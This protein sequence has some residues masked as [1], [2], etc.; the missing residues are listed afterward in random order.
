MRR[1]GLGLLIGGVLLN[2]G[3]A[4]QPSATGYV[5]CESHQLLWTIGPRAEE[6]F[7]DICNANLLTT[8]LDENYIFLP[9]DGVNPDTKQAVDSNRDGISDPGRRF[10]D[11]KD[12]PWI[13]WG[14]DNCKGR[15][16][17][18]TQKGCQGVGAEK[19]TLGCAWV[20]IQIQAKPK[21][22]A[23]HLQPHPVWLV[24]LPDGTE[25]YVPGDTLSTGF[26][27]CP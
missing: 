6:P 27:Q 24:R 1:A 21:R 17:R 9:I 13:R 22:P 15:V 18:I 14:A 8:E 16:Q 2:A 26:N 12:Q 3:C 4:T 5:G 20:S 19:R 11:K 23:T 10:V 7:L 25:Q